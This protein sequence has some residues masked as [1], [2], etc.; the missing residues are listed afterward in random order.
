MRQ[1]RG[2]PRFHFVER[3][4]H[5][6]F[7][8]GQADARV[9]AGEDVRDLGGHRAV[10]GVFKGEV[11]LLEILLRL[12]Q[13][14]GAVAGVGDFR[15]EDLHFQLEIVGGGAAGESEG[16]RAGMEFQADVF[17]RENTLE[18]IDAVFAEAARIERGARRA[19]RARACR[20]AG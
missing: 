6:H 5:H 20:R 10:G 7:F 3:A 11:K 18:F 2:E 16:I 19:Q 1:L 4:L 14:L 13:R 15:G 8:L 9:A 17:P 12:A